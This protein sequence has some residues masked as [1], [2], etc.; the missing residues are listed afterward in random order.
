MTLEGV[1][2]FFCWIIVVVVGRKNLELA[3]IGVHNDSLEAY[4]VF[5]VHGMMPWAEASLL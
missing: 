1:N 4:R 2:C 5:I 3:L